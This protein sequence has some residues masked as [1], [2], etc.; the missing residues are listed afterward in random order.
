MKKVKNKKTDEAVR[1]FRRV[2]PERVAS[3]EDLRPS[4]TKVKV[5]MYLDLDVLDYFKERARRPNAAPY[6]TQ[7]NHELRAMMEGWR[8]TPYAALVNDQ[9]FITAVAERVRNIGP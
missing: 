3:Q 9:Q 4:K 7:I 6:Q 1:R 5:T 8:E 2:T